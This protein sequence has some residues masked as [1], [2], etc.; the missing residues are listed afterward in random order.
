[1]HK[2]SLILFASIA[3]VAVALILVYFLTKDSPDLVVDM[4]DEEMGSIHRP[5]DRFYFITNPVDKRHV[6][7]CHDLTP[8]R[9]ISN[10]DPD[11]I[12]SADSYYALPLNI[13]VTTKDGRTH[14]IYISEM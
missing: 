12:E 11:G 9:I 4:T 10:F 3:A 7:L 1:M 13:T 2:G 5:I 6:M 8:P 14:S